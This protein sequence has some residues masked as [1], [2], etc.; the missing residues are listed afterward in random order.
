MTEEED[1]L[2]REMVGRKVRRELVMVM[3]VAIV[4]YYN[5]WPRSCHQSSFWSSEK[6]LISSTGL[7]G[8]VGICV[9]C[10]MNGAG[11]GASRN[12]CRDGGGSI[13]PEE[14][15]QVIIIGFT[16]KG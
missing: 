1:D 11:Y 10:D 6:Y 3:V 13:G 9:G 5:R 12:H 15:D 2:D 16:R 8:D 4:Y 14:L 7:G